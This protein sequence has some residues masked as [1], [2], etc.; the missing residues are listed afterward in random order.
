M[1][2]HPKKIFVNG[3][4]YPNLGSLP[5]VVRKVFED[6]DKNGIPDLLE[7]KIAGL[8]I[9]NLLSKTKSSPFMVKGNAYQSFD[10][11]PKEFQDIIRN[12]FGFTGTSFPS[13]P[14]N[15]G[16]HAPIAPS[17]G[18]DYTKIFVR[19]VTMIGLLFLAVG[20]GVFYYFFLRN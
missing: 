5:S 6:A 15:V 7:G 1:A 10:D 19:L 17:P 9:F 11:L 16:S 2:V 8:N 3:K 13:T 20:G 14:Q 12:K 18:R 4:E